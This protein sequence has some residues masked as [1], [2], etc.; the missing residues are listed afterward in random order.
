VSCVCAAGQTE[1]DVVPVDET[2]AY[3]LFLV[4]KDREPRLR[5]FLQR[6]EA[7]RAQLGVTDVQISL[8]SLEEVFLNIARKVRGPVSHWACPGAVPPRRSRRGMTGCALGQVECS[9]QPNTKQS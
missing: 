3:I 9:N 7:A 1:L 6:L 2:R 8:T 5:G 4:P